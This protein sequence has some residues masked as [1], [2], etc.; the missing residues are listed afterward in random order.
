M[1]SD[2]WKRRIHWQS[3]DLSSLFHD[4]FLNYLLLHHLTTNWTSLLLL[5]LILIHSSSKQFLS[6][7]WNHDFTLWTDSSMPLSSS[8]PPFLLETH[9]SNAHNNTFTHTIRP[10]LISF[11]SLSILHSLIPCPSIFSMTIIII[12]LCIPLPYLIFLLPRLS[13][14]FFCISER[15]SPITIEIRSRNVRSDPDLWLIND[16]IWTTIII[17]LIL[18]FPFL[19]SP[20]PFQTP[21]LLVSPFSFIS[22]PTIKVCNL[23]PTSISLLLNSL[24]KPGCRF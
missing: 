12:F 13:S 7:H 10:F 1:F 18:L 11:Y 5:I 4:Y 9:S 2:R 14:L 21:P 22:S 19:H 15:F 24:M 23:S 8:Q 20:K 17:N 6:Y 3:S 16:S